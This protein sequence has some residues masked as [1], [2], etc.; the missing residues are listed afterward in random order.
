ML[1]GRERATNTFALEG[2]APMAAKKHGKKKKKTSQTSRLVRSFI[3]FLIA[4]KSG[5]KETV[6]KAAAIVMKRFV[7]DEPVAGDKA[8]AAIRT[9]IDVSD[10]E[11]AY[12][13]LAELILP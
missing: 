8:D 1:K 7:R 4:L 5:D 11:N 12:E 13:F 6:R 10:A 3:F 2:E 9:I